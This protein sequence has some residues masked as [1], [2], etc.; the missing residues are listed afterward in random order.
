MPHTAILKQH[1]RL[2]PPPPGTQVQHQKASI[3]LCAVAVGCFI[4]PVCCY[5]TEANL[6]RILT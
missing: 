3:I 5:Y 4:A 6:R 1:G 2:Q